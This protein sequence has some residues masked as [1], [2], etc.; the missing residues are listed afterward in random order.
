MCVVIEVEFSA[1]G[2]DYFADTKKELPSPW[3][4]KRGKT[5][6]RKEHEEYLTTCWTL[7]WTWGHVY[8]IRAQDIGRSMGERDR[9]TIYHSSIAYVV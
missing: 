1:R 2:N 6:K 4:V 8:R 7:A 9:I 3:R 5:I